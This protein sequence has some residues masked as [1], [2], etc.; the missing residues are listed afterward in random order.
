MKRI[1]L[2][3]LIAAVLL[4]VSGLAIVTEYQIAEAAKEKAKAPALEKIEFIHWKKG[5]GKT[6]CNNDG[7][8][9]EGENPSC[10]DCKNNGDDEQPT[11]SCYALM[12]KYGKTLLQWGRLPVSYVINPTNP[13]GLSEAFVTS[14][15]SK[16]A[17]E[18]DDW[19]G[20]ELFND[21]YTI[22]YAATYGKQDNVNAITWGN[23]PTTGVIAVTAVWYN[24]ATKSIVEFDIMFDIDWTWGN[25][26]I[27]PEVMDL[28]NIAAHELGHAAG[29][30]DV[31]DVECGTVT[32]YG[33]SDNGETQKRSL[34]NPD[35][36]GIQ[37]LY[38]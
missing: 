18:W 24:P 34:E 16:G 9:D 6:P 2:A 8:C 26:T 19:T 35:I 22:D 10:T 17:E 23:Y 12:G 27:N 36:T 25:A 20:A 11:A 38:G 14:A 4:I 1:P 37:K 7:I 21:V 29:L 28:Q 13:D 3:I 30:A 32:M 33:Y 31:Y 5:F 15:I